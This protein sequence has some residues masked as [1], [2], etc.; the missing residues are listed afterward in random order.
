MR[1]EGILENMLQK[2]EILI[3]QI[4]LSKATFTNV[5]KGR[6]YSIVSKRNYDYEL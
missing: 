1:N 4:A 6:Q 3:F 2:F 5:Y